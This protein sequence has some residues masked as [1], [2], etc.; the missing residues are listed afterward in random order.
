MTKVNFSLFLRLYYI[1]LRFLPNN[2]IHIRGGVVCRLFALLLCVAS[3]TLN[4]NSLLAQSYFN[5]SLQITPNPTAQLATVYLPPTVAN[6]LLLL[7]LYNTN[8]QL[9]KTLPAQAG[10]RI[11]PID[12]SLLPQGTYILRCEQP[13]SNIAPA[14]LL[15]KR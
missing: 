9:V 1:V 4:S 11:V 6:Q 7:H 5:N 13:D 12:V 8:G 15:I 2:L 3:I 14:K 10:Q